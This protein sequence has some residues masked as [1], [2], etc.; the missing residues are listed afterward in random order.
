MA[1][2]V[3]LG[4][5]VAA[6]LAVAQAEVSTR[7]DIPFEGRVT[8]EAKVLAPG[9]RV[10]LDELSAELELATCHQM[11]FV[12]ST[13]LRGETIEVFTR[14][15]AIAWGIGRVGYNDG[16]VILVAPAMRKVRIETG[17]GMEARL[18]NLFLSEVIAISMLPAF[19]A[20]NYGEGLWAGGG[21]VSAK[22]RAQSP[23][24]AADS[25]PDCSKPYSSDPALTSPTP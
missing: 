25:K 20:G 6:A 23:G 19:E 21:A 10:R 8:D 9:D 17:L 7:P 1:V 18:P 22:L 15:L 12:T 13:D 3:F 11:V 24:H 5:A 16:V 2:T 14:R 4:V